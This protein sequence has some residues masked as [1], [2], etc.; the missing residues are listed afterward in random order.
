[1][2]PANWYS[3]QK[4]VQKECLPEI[5]NGQKFIHIR[6]EL[7][8]TAPSMKGSF[9]DIQ[10]INDYTICVDLNSVF[11]QVFFGETFV[12]KYRNFVSQLLNI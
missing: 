8:Y 7:P 9:V 3:S 11:A 5:N 6:F 12:T 10:N 2:N 4:S 1:M